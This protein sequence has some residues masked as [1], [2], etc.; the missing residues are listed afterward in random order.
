MVFMIEWA[1]GEPRLVIQTTKTSGCI[2]NAFEMNILFI[3]LEYSIATFSG[4]GVYSISQVRALQ[5]LGHHVYVI[6][7]RPKDNC[8]QYD[9]DDIEGVSSIPLNNWGSL[10]AKCDWEGF[11]SQAAASLPPHYLPDVVLCVDWHGFAAYRAIAAIQHVPCC[12]LNYRVHLRTADEG[13]RPLI[14]RMEGEALHHST[15]TV[16]LCH[17]DVSYLKA[18]FHLASNKI[19]SFNLHV[20]LPALR[21]DVALIAPPEAHT[22]RAILLSCVRIAQEKEPHRFVNLVIELEKRDVFNRS[23]IEPVMVGAGW[24]SSDYGVE[25]R[26]RIL[27]RAPRITIIEDF[28]GPEELANLYRRTLLNIHAPLAD[29]YGMTIVEAAS[30]QAPSLVH[31]GG[32]VGAAHLLEVVHDEIICTDMSDGDGLVHKVESILEDKAYLMKVGRNACSKARSY[33]EV[34]NAKGLMALIEESGKISV[35]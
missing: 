8:S 7:G 27:S 34:E 15:F 4:N 6:C 24:G 3:T 18:V 31:S 10:D 21:Q 11:A 35:N 23:G 32:D 25:L 26:D 14:S 17:S 19:T 20:L 28:L 29:A 5:A 13:S 1:V 16:S 30:Q 12:Y 22:E 33:D 2:L 9:F